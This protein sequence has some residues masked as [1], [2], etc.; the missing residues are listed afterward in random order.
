[1]REASGRVTDD[2]AVVSFLYELMRGYLQVADAETITRSVEGE[3][4]QT[5]LF[6]NGWLAQYAQ[7]IANRI[8]CSPN[9]DKD[10]VIRGTVE[11]LNAV[12]DPN[13]GVTADDDMLDRLTDARD[14]L[15]K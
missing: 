12:L 11:V 14:D 5:I 2:R 1:M 7:D 15:V 13:N 6:S 4:G 3:K 8:G 10:A 9:T